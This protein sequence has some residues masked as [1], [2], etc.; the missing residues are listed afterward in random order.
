[1]DGDR[2]DSL[3]QFF[4]RLE[5]ACKLLDEGKPIN[6]GF[7]QR[8]KSVR[9]YRGEKQEYEF[10]CIS[11]VGRELKKNAPIKDFQEYSGLRAWY[12]EAINT[13]EIGYSDND[14]V[15]LTWAR[16]HGLLT[17][18]TDWTTNPLVALWFACSGAN[19]EKDGVVYVVSEAP[20]DF[21]FISSPSPFLYLNGKSTYRIDDPTG[22]M[23]SNPESIFFRPQM[24]FHPRLKKQAGIFHVSI[25]PEKS[26][27]DY[28][29]R[30]AKIVIPGNS[31]PEVL[32]ELNACGIN[33]NSLGL[34]SPDS[35]SDEVNIEILKGSIG[36]RYGYY[37]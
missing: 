7:S 29:K 28:G 8:L 23:S 24:S 2:A 25:D 4:F 15:K 35:I 36:F 22:G 27:L 9:A 11:S 3:G 20:Y 30:T 33:S 1:M 5:S 21:D 26:A 17:R 12:E 14:W 19:C 10:P 6:F 34:S 31:K 18:L 37:D 16:H 32:F 13:E